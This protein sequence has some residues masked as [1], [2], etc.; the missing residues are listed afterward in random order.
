MKL[1]EYSS[2]WRDFAR[3]Y[4]GYS[5]VDPAMSARKRSGGNDND[6][7][8]VSLVQCFVGGVL[9]TLDLV[10]DQQFPSL[11]FGYLQVVR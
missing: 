5:I 1:Q 6:A 4:S 3:C 10:L 9:Q 8:K 2:V 7:G 11:Q